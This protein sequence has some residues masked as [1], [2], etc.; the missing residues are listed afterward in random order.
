MAD[1]S[2]VVSTLKHFLAREPV[3]HIGI[4]VQDM[5]ESKKFYSE[6]LGGTF[7]VEA[8]GITSDPWNEI[9]N[10]TAVA[11]GKKVPN[12]NAG[13]ALHVAFYSFGNMAVELLRYYNVETGETFPGPVVGANEQGPAGM[14]ICFNLAPNVDSKEFIIKLKEQC[15]GMANVSVNMPD[16]FHLPTNGGPMDGWCLA[17]MSGPSNERI[18]FLQLPDDSNAM[19]KFQ[20]SHGIFNATHA[21][22]APILTA[23][24]MAE[25][26]V[27]HIVLMSVR[28]NL[29][30]ERLALMKK[31]VLSLK[32]IPGTVSITFG[33]STNPERGRGYTHG[34]V[35]RHINKAAA[36]AYQISPLHVKVRDV[37]LVPYL[38][39]EH[40]SIAMDWNIDPDSQSRS[41]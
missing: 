34:V 7:I 11:E 1:N 5:E 26:M 37:E 29:S 25:P 15:K 8:D 22:G 24:Q 2:S 4:N 23:A 16:L 13:D 14:H 17:F 35:V 19:M 6:V 20:A 10:G 40:P 27:E 28:E 18:E 12:L 21:P 31:A 38:N 9:L 32:D 39:P 33:P 41:F 36:A 3:Q 30:K